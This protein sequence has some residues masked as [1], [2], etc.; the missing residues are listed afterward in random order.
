MANPYLS[1]I[2]GINWSAVA[3]SQGPSAAQQ[4]K[5]EEEASWR[6]Q[7]GL[8]SRVGLP[9]LG[10]LAGGLVGGAG[11]ALAGGL[12][13]TGGGAVVI[14]GVG[15]IPGAAVGAIGGGISGASTGAGVGG[16]LGYAAGNAVGGYFDAEADKQYDPLRRQEMNQLQKRQALMEL[17][18]GMR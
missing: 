13:G 3:P 14:P 8:V 9:V 10:T 1:R 18:A 6:R 12:T 2:R 15:A 11:G 17:L 16:G 5:A 4:R 7:L